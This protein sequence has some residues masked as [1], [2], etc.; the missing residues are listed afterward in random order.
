M[1]ANLPTEGR[2][3][4]VPRAAELA[5]AAV[6]ICAP[7]D[8]VAEARARAGAA[9]AALCVVVSEG[10]VVL[11]LLREKQLAEEPARTVEEVMLRAPSTF[12]PFV[13]A[14]EMAEYMTKHD[15][16][17]SPITTLDGRLLGMLFRE[18]AVRAARRS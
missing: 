17:S 11:G 8:T 13:L 16:E 1:A 15:L 12:R 3:R 2:K 10:G 7:A 6:P 9:G 5:R 14:D 4:G 18:D